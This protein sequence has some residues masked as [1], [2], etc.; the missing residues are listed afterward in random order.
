MSLSKN[1][2]KSTAAVKPSYIETLQPVVK[3]RYVEKL[4]SMGSFDPYEVVSKKWSNDE[5]TLPPV[6]CE[7]I[8]DYL[9]VRKSA[10][11]QQDFKAVKSIGAHNQVTSGWVQE[12]LIFQ[13]P[14]TSDTANIVVS[15]KVCRSTPSSHSMGSSLSSYTFCLLILSRTG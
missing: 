8:V 4:K 3:A 10:Y 5:N 15:A 9:L 2:K 1:A 14:K 12:V 7:D 6:G 13:P 11:T